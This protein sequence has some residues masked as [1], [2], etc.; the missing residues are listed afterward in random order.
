MLRNFK[1]SSRLNI[2][3]SILISFPVLSMLLIGGGMI[4]L[5]SMAKQQIADLAFVLEKQKIRSNTHSM[6]LALG[7]AIAN[8]KDSIKQIGLLCEMISKIRFETDLSSYFFIF[9]GTQKI[10]WPADH[11]GEY[12][13]Q[14]QAS[15]TR[16]TFYIK[17][18]FL[19]ASRG[20]D[21]VITKIPRNGSLSDKLFYSEM[22]PGTEY[23]IGTGVFLDIIQHE[24]RKSESFFQKQFLLILFISGSLLVLLVFLM[25]GGAMKI[26]NSIVNPLKQS[27]LITKQV[28]KGEL[29]EH[30]E[31][32]CKDEISELINLLLDMKLSLKGVV[33]KI[34]ETS[35][36]LKNESF[37][38]KYG[39][40]MLSQ[41]AGDQGL[42]VAAVLSAL[43]QILMNIEQT[44]LHAVESDRISAQTVVE[45]QRTGTV[46][47]EALRTMEIISEKINIIEEISRQ[48]NLLALNASI[49][50]AR[51]GKH[52]LGFS[53]VA[54]E[55]RKLAERSQLASKEIDTLSKSGFRKATE[56]RQLIENLI[57]ESE[58]TSD[59][60]SRVSNANGLLK[61]SVAHIDRAVHDLDRIS[62]ANRTTAEDLSFSS[63]LLTTEAEK[64]NKMMSFF[65]ISG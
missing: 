5:R 27:L 41:G 15:G 10:A 33:A 19:N 24:Q 53:V 50:A 57:L 54:A 25:F 65:K 62:G 3:L 39:M 61:E 9:R 40:E 37:K 49:E 2:I 34:G 29:I 51:A 44:S 14:A 48:T 4:S 17:Q 26:K 60:A 42:S 1:I 32:Q 31:D 8:E 13:I 21:Y 46:V 43:E 35:L 59:L 12:D 63:E 6:A 16:S 28:A 7:A 64:L 36:L 52:G 38:L 23:W 20:N 47:K 11:L 18:L 55:V 45:A 56:A 30:D 58:K 22:V